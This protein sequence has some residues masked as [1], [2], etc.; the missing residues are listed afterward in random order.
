MSNVDRDVG[1]LEPLY[2]VGGISNDAV[3]V[4]NS[5]AVGQKNRITTGSSDFTSKYSKEQKAETFK[6]FMHQYLL[7]LIQNNQEEATQ[8]STKM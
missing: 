6:V 7:K 8:T 1:K 4:E 5:M 3:T 2:T